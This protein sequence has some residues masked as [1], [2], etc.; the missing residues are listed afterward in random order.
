MEIEVICSGCERTLKVDAEHAGKTVRCPV[1]EAVTL[2]G[3]VVETGEPK[4][5]RMRTPEGQIF[6]PVTRT[7]LDDWVTQGRVAHD[8][9]LQESQADWQKAFE[10]FPALTPVVVKPASPFVVAVAAPSPESGGAEIDGAAGAGPV[11]AQFSPTAPHIG[12]MIPHR[13]GV[14][15]TLGILCWLITCPVFSVMAWV[16][17]TSDLRDMRAGRMDPSGMP[18]TQAGQ[19]LG[20]INAVLWMIVGVLAMLFLVIGVAS[21]A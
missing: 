6:G 20:M 3:E 16:M 5:W 13:G 10:V 2:A 9:Q 18:Q 15:L 12:Y 21:G 1:C 8:C 7:E 14:I 11:V 19:V 17:G 4:V